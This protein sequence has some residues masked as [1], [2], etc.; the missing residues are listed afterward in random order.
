[1]ILN[2]K[3]WFTC[4]SLFLL[5]TG[6]GTKIGTRDV[7]FESSYKQI[8][9]VAL[10]G[11][12]LSST[13]KSVL[14][15]HNL[16][17]SF[18]TAPQITLT[19]LQKRVITDNRRDLL[20]ALAELSY[21]T[22]QQSVS[23][24][25]DDSPEEYRK[26]YLNAAILAYYYLFAKNR[27]L[28]VDAYDRNFRWACD[29]YNIALA[30]SLTD[31]S[32]HLSIENGIHSHATGDIS[33]TVY[34]HGFPLKAVSRASKVIAIDKLKIVGFSRH[35]RE[36]GIGMPFMTILN[37]GKGASRTMSLPGTL[38]LKPAGGLDSLYSHKS[39]AALNLY[40]AF[41][42][43]HIDIDGT[44]VPIEKDISAHVA[45]T[46]DQSQLSNVGIKGFFTGTIPYKAGIY[47]MTPFHPGKIPVVFVHG[48]F[49]NPFS[50]AEM[51]NTLMADAVIRKRFQ[52]WFYLYNTNK[53]VF[54]SARFFRKALEEQI[55][56]CGA[57]RTN[58]FLQQ[59]VVIGHSQ[60]GLLTKCVTTDTGDRILKE[61]TGKALSE[62]NFS[63][64]QEKIL[65]EMF[66]LESLPFITRAIFISTPHRG[67]RLAK[68]WMRHIL[69]K[70]VT[71]PGA[72]IKT[73][74]AFM[75]IFPQD[76]VAK[77][78]LKEYN[79]TSV[80]GMTPDNPLLISMSKIPLSPRVKAHSIIAIN[81]DGN[82]EEGSDGVVTY[83]SAH[84]DY[85]ESEY[86]VQPSGH[87][88][89]WHPLSIEEVRRILHQHLIAGI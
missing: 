21:H 31:A 3:I 45:Y 53:P 74:A 47:Q 80:D 11:Q 55:R 29:I 27:D 62:I 5:A 76:D 14:Q 20:F 82:P 57:E 38:V 24:K 73:T 65:K 1:M 49:S 51:V 25:A 42:S 41:D 26:Y 70:F 56:G 64:D 37:S 28:P 7:G 23:H 69:Q 8:N 9:T 61:V 18:R 19:M 77:K 12:E 22:A 79:F 83:A 16:E 63:E 84:V 58:P 78:K 54:S 67:S 75:K 86:I 2:P 34:D 46:L 85:V 66:I 50:W 87:S 33:L 6:C 48:T 88:S 4:L 43:S 10:L 68:S 72:V 60:G 59:M 35:N 39:E 40:S 89:Q 71:L 32:G 15:R 30:R 44:P 13:S 81:N 36:A 17:D 52:F